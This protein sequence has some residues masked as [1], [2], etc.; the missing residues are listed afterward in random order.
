MGGGSV[1]NGATPLVDFTL[2]VVLVY[3]KNQVI[4]TNAPAYSAKCG[5]ERSG[6]FSF[7]LQQLKN[8]YESY[9]THFFGRYEASAIN[10]DYSE[11]S[12][13]KDEELCPGPAFKS[14]Y[15]HLKRFR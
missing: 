10:L 3:E 9:N 2:V 15:L 8:V 1:I 5:P 7:Q 12:K 14:L 6:N 11:L 4:F 13:L